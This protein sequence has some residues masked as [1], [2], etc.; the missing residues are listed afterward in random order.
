M[1]VHNE[2]LS[3]Y[4]SWRVGGPAKNLF[5]PEELNDLVNFLKSLPSDEKIF[6]IG[7]GSNLLVRDNGFNGTVIVTQGSFLNKIENLN[8]NNKP[9]TEIMNYYLTFIVKFIINI[10]NIINKKNVMQA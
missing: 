8:N 4:T 6:W 2:S 10:I 1:L 5:I 7:L 9:K 3:K